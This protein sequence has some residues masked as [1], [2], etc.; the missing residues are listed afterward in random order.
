MVIGESRSIPACIKVKRDC[1]DTLV[2]YHKGVE[3]SRT[4]R[5]LTQICPNCVDAGAGIGGGS[6]ADL[7]RFIQNMPLKN[8]FTTKY[9]IDKAKRSCYNDGVI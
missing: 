7:V 6:G 8:N 9:S 3:K 2:F 4:I 5:L 1:L